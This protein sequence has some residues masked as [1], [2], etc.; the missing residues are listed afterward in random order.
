LPGKNPGWDEDKKTLA[1]EVH[2]NA[3]GAEKILVGAS[4]CG[5]CHHSLEE[6]LLVSFSPERA[7]DFS[8]SF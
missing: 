1:E 3:R 5:Q 6:L 4:T 7:D 8:R 2:K